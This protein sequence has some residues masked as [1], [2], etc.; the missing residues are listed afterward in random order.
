MKKRL[1]PYIDNVPKDW[2][3]TDI[4]SCFH[5]K[6]STMSYSQLGNIDSSENDFKVYG[7][8]VSDMNLSG[9]SKFIINSNLIKYID[10]KQINK[11]LP[12]GTIIFPKR[13]AAIRTN[14]KR[15]LTEYS[16]IDPNIMGLVPKD[17]EI[18]SYFIYFLLLTF[19]LDKITDPGPTPQLNKKDLEPLLFYKPPLSEQQ[20]IAAVLTTVQRSI[21]LQNE[22]I[23]RTTELKKSMMHKLFTEGVRGERQKETEI[24]MVPESWEVVTVEQYFDIKSS[25]MSYTQLSNLENNEDGIHVLGVKVSDMNIDGNHKYFLKSNLIKKIKVPLLNKTLPKDTII[26]PKRGA[27]IATNKKRIST[28]NI[29]LDPNLIGLMPKGDI[30]PDYFYFW[31]L[32]FDLAKITDPGP[33]PQLNKKDLEPLKFPLPS[34]DEQEQ[35]VKIL[36][37][38][39]EKKEMHSIKKQK[40]EELF[41]TILQQLMTAQV[42]VNGLNIKLYGCED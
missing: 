16:V 18:D 40:F 10:K 4:G 15:I 39:D 9:N 20:I 37:K 1:S 7:I 23:E 11:T 13:G 31:L 29:V 2:I 41:R 5:I 30:L 22:L 25:T 8:K 3:E 24:G 27:A 14:K 32:T 6:S 12:P 21:E 38:I 19:D 28:S 42:R 36:S 17:N 35:I 34:T 33:T 26:F